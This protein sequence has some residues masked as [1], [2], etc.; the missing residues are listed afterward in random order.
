MFLNLAKF[1]IILL[2]YTLLPPLTTSL[3]LMANAFKAKLANNL[4]YF[5]IKV[6]SI[7]IWLK[8]QRKY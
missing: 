3:I 4:I 5:N 1:S 7:A 8:F 2:V 6:S